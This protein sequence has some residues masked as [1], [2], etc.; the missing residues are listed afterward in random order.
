MNKNCMLY[1]FFLFFTLLIR[2]LIALFGAYIFTFFVL[3]LINYINV[4]WNKLFILFPL[5]KLIG[6]SFVMGIT[7][8]LWSIHK[9]RKSITRG[10]ES[11]EILSQHG[12]KAEINDISPLITIP[13]YQINGELFHNHYPLTAR[14]VSFA[15]GGLKKIIKKSEIKNIVINLVDASVD[16]NKL[17]KQLLNKYS[18]KLDK[19]LIIDKSGNVISLK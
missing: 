17:K 16:I 8:W 2:S 15:L 12:Y 14:D 9:Y 4:D 11:L 1:F 10:K 18:D 6:G 5:K 7:A 13:F 19:I 3:D